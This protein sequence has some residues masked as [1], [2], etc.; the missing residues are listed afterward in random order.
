[1]WRSFIRLHY[2]RHGVF[3]PHGVNLDDYVE[4]ELNL[5]DV[6]YVM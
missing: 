4:N 6:R 1:M 5:D 3:M 2:D